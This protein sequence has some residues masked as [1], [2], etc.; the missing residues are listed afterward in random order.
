MGAR[1]APSPAQTRAQIIITNPLETWLKA[2][3]KLK[4]ELKAT[5]ASSTSNTALLSFAGGTTIAINM[6]YMAMPRA[7]LIEPGS[8]IP[9]PAPR[10]VPRAQPMYGIVSSPNIY[11]CPKVQG[12]VTETAKIS[13]VTP[14][15]IPSRLRTPVRLS[16]F[17]ERER[18]IREYLRFIISWVRA[19][20][21]YDAPPSIRGSPAN[22]PAEVRFVIEMSR[23]PHTGRPPLTAIIPNVKETDRYPSPIGIPSFNPCK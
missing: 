16:S 13:S 10:R 19:A 18:D 11:R 17:W 14:K 12:L 9:A 3:I 15:E 5:E 7:L 21:K 2:G 8:S 1:T 20:S 6:P 23:A 4:Q 22:C